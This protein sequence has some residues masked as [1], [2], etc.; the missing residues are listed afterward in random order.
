M[1]E[2]KVRPRPHPI[3]RSAYG[4]V[5]TVGPTIAVVRWNPACHHVPAPGARQPCR[6]GRDGVR[7]DG[8]IIRNRA[9]VPFDSSTKA[10]PASAG[11]GALP[12]RWCAPAPAS[13][14]STSKTAEDGVAARPVAGEARNGVPPV[15]AMA[16][17][18]A[19][20]A[21]AELASG[22]RPCKIDS[23]PHGR[24]RVSPRSLHRRP[25]QS[26]DPTQDR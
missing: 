7:G 5:S 19:P 10:A 6:G 3:P 23:P 9:R 15:P 24:F 14:A 25:R 16:C 2:S 20:R 11:G 18:R 8:W 26:T 21:L 17:P 4:S 13:A 1:T 12:A 22:R